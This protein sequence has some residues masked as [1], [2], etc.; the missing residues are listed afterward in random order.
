MRLVRRIT[1]PWVLCLCCFCGTAAGAVTANCLGEE[2]PEQLGLFLAIYQ[3]SGTLSRTEMRNLLG[4]A[5][6]QRLSEFGLAALIGLTPFSAA[7]FAAI[8]FAGGFCLGFLHAAVTLLQGIA[9][10]L[11]FLSLLMPHWL[12][13]LPA[14]AILAVQ[15]EDGLAAMKPRRWLLATLLVLGGIWMEAYVNPG[16]LCF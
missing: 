3:R 15:A 14:W 13:Y 4:Y 8:A 7:G 10:I 11:S 5:A 9:G 2:L 1:F 12:C 6:R 16:F